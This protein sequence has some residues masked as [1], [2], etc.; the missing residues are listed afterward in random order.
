S[1]LRHQRSAPHIAHE[2]LQR[3]FR[4][5]SDRIRFTDEATS[6][7]R[8]GVGVPR[9]IEVFALR[10]RTRSELQERRGERVPK[11]EAVREVAQ[12]RS[13]GSLFLEEN[14]KVLQHAELRKRVAG[15]PGHR[16]AG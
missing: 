15:L 11:S 10:I 9:R 4:S 3:R 16:V 14:P 6:A 5:R 12:R 8:M 7:K 1:A 13:S 2:L